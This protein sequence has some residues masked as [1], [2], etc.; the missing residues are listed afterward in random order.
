MSEMSSSTTLPDNAES[1]P[2]S[3]KGQWGITTTGRVF[4]LQLE[5]A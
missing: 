5:H 2:S 3:S 1:D 4:E